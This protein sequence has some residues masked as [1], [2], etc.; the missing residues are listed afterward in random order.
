MYENC[1]FFLPIKYT[2]GGLSQPHST[3]PGVLILI[4]H[5]RACG[6][7]INRVQSWFP[8]VKMTLMV[9][10]VLIQNLHNRTL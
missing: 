1:I 3:L 9:C 8:I 7:F 6:V 4:F 5:N 2:H 10:Q